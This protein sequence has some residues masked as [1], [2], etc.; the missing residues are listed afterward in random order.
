MP[1]KAIP[2][3]ITAKTK[4][5][6]RANCILFP[7]K[8]VESDFTLIIRQK[9]SCIFSAK[10]IRS[11][12]R[13]SLNQTDE[14]LTNEKFRKEKL[15]KTINWNVH[16]LIAGPVMGAILLMAFNAPGQNLF[17]ADY[18]V[19]KIYEFTTNGAESTFASGLDGPRGL[20]FN[21]N[22]N[23]FEADLADNTI[24][25]FTPAGAKTAFA[26]AFE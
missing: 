25:E 13:K 3:R 5:I 14:T 18:T 24:D 21:S 15:L 19:G 11:M 17:V 9:C 7:F 10:G 16:H 23:L 1:G 2:F 4:G 20:A 22:S 6:E 8:P 12:D 26:T